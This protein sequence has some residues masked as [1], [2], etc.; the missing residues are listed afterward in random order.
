[1]N[2]KR[3]KYFVF[4]LFFS[5]LSV[6]AQ[7][8][9]TNEKL[10]E[11]AMKNVYTNPLKSIEIGEAFLANPGNE[12]AMEFRYLMLLAQAYVMIPDYEKSLDYASRAYKI[13][14][15]NKLYP[16]Q[17]NASTFLG[18]HY[19]RLKL[20]EKSWQALERS[21]KIIREHPL[22]DS[23]DHIQGNVYLL[24][25]YLFESDAEY[26]K[27]IEAFTK[28]TSIFKKTK[29][30]ELGR[31]N[32]GVALTH[33]GRVQIVDNQ[34]DSAE[35]SFQEVIKISSL[36]KQNGVDAFAYLSLAEVYSR[37][38]KFEKSNQTLFQALEISENSSQKE[39][40]K[41]IYKSLADNFFK[42][43]NLDNYSKYDSLYKKALDEFN[44]SEINSVQKLAKSVE[45]SAEDSKNR[46]WLIVISCA[47]LLILVSFLFF[48]SYGLKKKMK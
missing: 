11:D 39:L 20:N 28:A 3:I 24:K 19:L 46:T 42:M 35:F 25:G 18:N 45:N 29:N 38:E 30:Q 33:K 43:N 32:T 6:H 37:Q 31:I 8:I 14:E 5:F 48:R 40:E 17:I 22:P 34:L 27:A 12:P 15:E 1:M 10:L 36:N 26:T 2:A 16:N 41:E 21:E 7:E 47:I 9:K 4:L 44:Q 13:A 23:L